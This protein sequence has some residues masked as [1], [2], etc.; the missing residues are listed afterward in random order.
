MKKIDLLS[1]FRYVGYDWK[2]DLSSIKKI[3]WLTKSR[4][5]PN[6]QEFELSY[7]MEQPFLVKAVAEW[8]D[9]SSFFEIGTG[10]GTA[11]YTI[12]L[13]DNIKKIT[14]IDIVPFKTKRHEAIGYEPAFVSNHDLYNMVPFEEKTKISFYHRDQ[15]GEIF[16]NSRDGYDLFFIDGNHSDAQVIFEDFEICKSIS[17]E[18]S[19]IIWDDYDPNKFAVRPVVEMVQ[20]KYPEYDTLLVEFRG[21]LFDNKPAETNAGMVLMIRGKFNEDIFTQVE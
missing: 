3:C 15:I 13:L 17:R 18:N 14:T 16:A 10:R 11:C 21:H 7:G 9:Y 20:K 12:S 6:K 5:N 1:F 19:I 4:A 8:K 2:S